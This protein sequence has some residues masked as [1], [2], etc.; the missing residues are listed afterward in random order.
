MSQMFVNVIIFLP[1]NLECV[2]KGGKII[3]QD[4]PY[5]LHVA[6]NRESL[7]WKVKLK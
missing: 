2:K 5:W 6:L 1:R 7:Q 4:W 3:A